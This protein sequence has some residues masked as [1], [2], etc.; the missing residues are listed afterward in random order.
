MSNTGRSRDDCTGVR[1]NVASGRLR[2]LLESQKP[3]GVPDK[4]RPGPANSGFI[5]AL[6]KTGVR[7]AMVDIGLGPT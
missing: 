7:G 1:K 3:P 2:G 6:L 5:V 4:K